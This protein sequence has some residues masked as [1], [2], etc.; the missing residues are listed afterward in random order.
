MADAVSID[1]GGGI[2]T[3]VDR[4]DLPVVF[5]FKWRTKVSRHTTYARASSAN[6]SVL[7]HRLIIGAGPGEIVDHI[8]RNGL[9]NRRSNLRIVSHSHNSA[10]AEVRNKHGYRGIFLNYAS[11]AKPWSAR[12]RLDGKN[13]NFGRHATA[14][15]AARAHDIGI[16]KLRGDPALMNFPELAAA[17]QEAAR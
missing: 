11:H 5:P 13:I 6:K 15:E 2:I 1:L 16:F 4:Y 12:A 3:F 14:E 9:N 8:D 7:M 17:L 10:N